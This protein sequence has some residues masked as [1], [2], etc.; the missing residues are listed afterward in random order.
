MFS[1][2][3]LSTMRVFA[4]FSHILLTAVLYWCRNDTIGVTMSDQ[5]YANQALF[6]HYDRQLQLL[7]GLNFICL[8]I[9][10]IFFSFYSVNIRLD[11]CLHL[12]VD[13]AAS[14]F[15]IWIILDGWSWEVFIYLFLFCSLLP[16]IYDIISFLQIQLQ[17]Q[18]VNSKKPISIAKALWYCWRPRP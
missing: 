17:K 3:P 16:A 12:L 13:V 18:F 14:F 7:I 11:S 8:A 1:D 2:F 5:N 9:K 10:S 4:L 6:A 15:L